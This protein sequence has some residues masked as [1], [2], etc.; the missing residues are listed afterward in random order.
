MTLTEFLL[1]RISE[2]EEWARKDL[3]NVTAPPN[4]MLIGD[5]AVVS[6]GER[7]LAECAA[8]RRVVEN[9]TA[10]AA[11]LDRQVPGMRAIL[12]DSSW[13]LRNIGAIYADH[14]DWRKEWKL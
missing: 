9:A 5:R 11:S 2:D 3:A 6:P 13:D 4:G 7:M 8:K 10:A 12:E 1:A 14:P